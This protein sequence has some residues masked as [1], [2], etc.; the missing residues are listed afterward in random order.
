MTLEQ[1]RERVAREGKRLG[2][3]PFSAA[4]G[5][6]KETLRVFA[7]TPDRDLQPSTRQALEGYF[8]AGG[9][10]LSSRDAKSVAATVLLLRKALLTQ[11]ELLARL[12]ELSDIDEH[13]DDELSRQNE[14]GDEKQA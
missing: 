11:E 9:A 1:L 7:T 3:Q 10:R 12:T 8:E 6:A 2:W 4:V 5:V 13:V 14:R